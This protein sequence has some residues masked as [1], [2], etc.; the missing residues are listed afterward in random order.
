M[1]EK[2]K[3]ELVSSILSAIQDQDPWEMEGEIQIQAHFTTEQTRGTKGVL[4]HHTGNFFCFF[5]LFFFF[6]QKQYI[7]FWRFIL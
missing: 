1:S 6:K 7:K 3:G 5:R 2:N 4:Y